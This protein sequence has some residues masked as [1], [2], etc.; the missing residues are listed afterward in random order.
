MSD[1]KRGELTAHDKMRDMLN[2]TTACEKQVHSTCEKQVHSTCEQRADKPDT[3][4][5]LDR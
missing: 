5:L 4:E 2:R 1:S 3:R